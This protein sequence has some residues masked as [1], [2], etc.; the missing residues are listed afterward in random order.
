[1]GGHVGAEAI[2]RWAESRHIPLAPTET[3]NASKDCSDC[4]QKTQRLQVAIWQIPWW[5]ILEHNWQVKLILVAPGGYKWV[6]TG[7]DMDNGLGLAY[8]V[9]DA[10]AQSVMKEPEQKILHQFRQLTIISS[11]QRKKLVV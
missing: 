3:Q 5:E 1:M 11:N 7:I 2:Q 8:L 10:N 6:L 9:V 4:P